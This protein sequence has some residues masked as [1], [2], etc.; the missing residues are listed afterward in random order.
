MRAMLAYPAPLDGV[1]LKAAGTNGGPVSHASQRR[2]PPHSTRVRHHES[3]HGALRDRGEVVATGVISSRPSDV[4]AFAAVWYQL[5]V[6]LTWRSSRSWA[7][8]QNGRQEL[9]VAA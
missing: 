7:K 4:T 6:M 1:Q 3:R 9:R 8:R 5:D 2:I